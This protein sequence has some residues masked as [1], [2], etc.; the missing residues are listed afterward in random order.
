MRKQRQLNRLRDFAASQGLQ[1]AVE[2][3]EIASG[4]NDK[5][6]KLNRLL[7]D[8][9]IGII[10]VENK[11]RLTRFGF[12]YIQALL[13]NQNRQVLLLNETDTKNELVDDFIS[14]INSMCAR[15]YGRRSAKR[16]AQ[17]VRDCIE[18]A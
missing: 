7:A 15:I 5:R 16:K 11:D 12:N 17:K 6:P 14:I 2:I 1:I 8:S 4:L 13:Q 18:Q 3:S 10:V 9:S